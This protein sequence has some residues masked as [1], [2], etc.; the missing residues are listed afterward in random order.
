[1]EKDYDKV[2][3]EAY[4]RLNKAQKEA[5]DE[6][7]G[8]VMVIA[9]PGTGKTQILTMRIANICR[10]TDTEPENIL[11]LT[12]TEAAASSMKR[13]LVDLMG[14]GGYQVM[15]STFHG[16]ANDI[17][18]NFPEEFPRLIGAELLSDVTRVKL[19]REVV[20]E[21][22]LEKLKSA[23]KPDYYLRAI[24]GAINELKREGVS[25]DEFAS[26]VREEKEG[27]DLIEDLYHDTGAYKGKKKGKYIELEK[28]IA[29]REELADI[30]REYE[31]KLA[32]ERYYDY[33]DMLMEALRAL[34]ENNELLL[35]IQER[36]QYILVDEHQDTNRTQNRI[37]ELIADF[38]ASP[39]VFIVGDEKQ[40]IYRFQGASLENFTYFHKLYP[41]SKFIVLEENYRSTQTILDSAHS[42]LAGKR[43][44][45]ARSENKDEKIKVCSFT[46]PYAEL[47]FVADD[48]K[49]KL[50]AGVPA[51]EI[52]ILYR[53]NKDSREMAEMLSRYKIPFVIDPGE[54]ILY[55]HLI[56]KIVV[57]LNAIENF[58]SQRELIEAMHI[59]CFRIDQ[60][61]IV[62][63]LAAVAE[64][65]TSI[66]DI[67]ESD[68]TI[69]SLK[70]KTEKRVKHFYSFIKHR[71]AEK[72]NVSLLKLY[73]DVIKKSGLMRQV[74]SKG[75]SIQDLEKIN[76]LFKELKRFIQTEKSV[77][78]AKF[79]EHLEIMKENGFSLSKMILSPETRKVKLMTAHKSKGLEFGFVYLINAV[80]NTWE[81]KKEKNLLPLPTKVYSIE[82]NDEL[83]EGER[84][85]DERRL[86]YVALTRAKI[87]MSV[88]YS[89]FNEEG[90]EQ[91]PTV[92]VN[93]MKQDLLDYLDMAE[94]EKKISKTKELAFGK[95][96]KERN[97][98]ILDKE[99]IEEIV[100]KKGFSPTDINNF[101][102][103]PWKYFYNNLLRI[104][105]TIT[106]SSAYGTAVHAA[107]EDYFRKMQ[108]GV[109]M[110]AAKVF[111]S[112]RVNLDRQPIIDADKKDLIKK[113][114]KSIIGF[115][116]HYAGTWE[117]NFLT[118]TPISGGEVEGIPIKGRIDRIEL[119]N[120]GKVRVIDF[121][122]GKY[123]TLG[124]I[125]GTTQNSNGDIKR[126]IVFYKLLL[127]QFK[128]KKYVF[129]YGTV[130][131][132][133]PDE[134]GNFHRE[135]LVPDE[136]DVNKLIEEIKFV[137]DE[138]VNL[139]FWNRR[140][141]DSK[142]E[143]CRMRDLRRDEPME[144]EKQKFGDVDNSEEE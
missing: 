3:E 10:K 9:G 98:E 32:A 79:L 88:S 125:T 121:K 56:S 80:T 117:R 71:S 15:I 94:Y 103:C 57:I 109:T 135:D 69:G 93:E 59:D 131:F 38:H 51:E 86:F 141:G 85:E 73:E 39:N 7:D 11:A 33:N 36:Y 128:D 114:E 13:R 12:F 22:P 126:Q 137:Y 54:S 92:F 24:N 37:V 26:I 142:C 30:Y 82:G 138:V 65:R 64:A 97:D 77:T 124:E 50:V 119:L 118:E 68:E 1:M 6:I 18:K 83:A 120:N 16:F 136:A 19:L 40:A 133:E 107:L 29:K 113:G 52:A 8:P 81:G 4:G 35:S 105:Q 102:N 99:M 5:V 96:D 34:K 134:K 139:K 70:L 47:K 27:F 45:Q 130:D 89:K 144:I 108:N 17:I 66:Y 58:G 101:L 41:R 2:F 48:I 62:K 100:L 115:I 129:D 49:N 21:L 72:G 20:S 127:K 67:L 75:N 84:I 78:L 61:D 14:P 43:P 132:V 63:I 25:V 111:E 74:V 55:D 110:T 28:Q 95:I 90:R 87:G 46:N 140:C 123:K 122:T 44:L 23:Y 106:K 91:L 143:Y 42:V 104:P 60:F 76:G 112:F 53:E 116:N 31:N